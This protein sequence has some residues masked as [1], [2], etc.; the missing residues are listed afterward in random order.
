MHDVLIV[1]DTVHG[2]KIIFVDHEIH[3]HDSFLFLGEGGKGVK[4]NVAQLLLTEQY[5]TRNCLMHIYMVAL[6]VVSV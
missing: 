1:I 6:K 4:G 3:T 2:Q 5:L